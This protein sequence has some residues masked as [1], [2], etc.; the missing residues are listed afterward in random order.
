M[1]TIRPVLTY[2]LP[3]VELNLNITMA[4]SK[5]KNMPGDTDSKQTPID[6]MS[7]RT[8]Q[9]DQDPNPDATRPGAKPES[10]SNK[11]S[12]VVP[13]SPNQGTESR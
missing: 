10:P 4:T 5:D 6:P 7:R 12:E 13:G 1:A 8:G 3:F 2:L 11:N 9:Q